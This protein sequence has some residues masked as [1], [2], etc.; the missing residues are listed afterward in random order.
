MLI[1]VPEYRKLDTIDDNYATASKAHQT[2]LE[3][4]QK[5]LHKPLVQSRKNNSEDNRNYPIEE[6][7]QS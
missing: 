2:L 1:S 4:K 3:F 5:A 6:V 7:I